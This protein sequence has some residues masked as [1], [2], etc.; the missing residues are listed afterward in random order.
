M[1]SYQWPN[2]KS[3]LRQPKINKD[4]KQA[5]RKGPCFIG[6]CRS[7]WSLE[8]QNKT[9]QGQEKHS[10]AVFQLSAWILRII[11]RFHH[12]NDYYKINLINTTEENQVQFCLKMTWQSLLNMLQSLFINTKIRCDGVNF[13]YYRCPIFKK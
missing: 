8:P 6:N 11:F 3:I 5:T 10:L 9:R 12:S 13:T 4:C 7:A 1:W 2:Q